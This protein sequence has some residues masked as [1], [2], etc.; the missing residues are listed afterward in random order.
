[1]GTWIHEEKYVLFR[2]RELTQDKPDG[3]FGNIVAG[4]DYILS[5][6]SSYMSSNHSSSENHSNDIK[7]ELLDLLKKLPYLDHYLFKNDFKTVIKILESNN[8]NETDKQKKILIIKS[9]QRKLSNYGYLKLYTDMLEKFLKKETPSYY[10]IDVLLENLLFELVSQGH[11]LLYIQEWLKG[12]QMQATNFKGF[13]SQLLNDLGKLNKKNYDCYLKFK[14]PAYV[15]PNK[16]PNM[17]IYINSPPSDVSASLESFFT[18][19]NY[20]A[21]VKVSALDEFAAIEKSKYLLENALKTQH[22]YQLEKKNNFNEYDPSIQNDVILFLGSS[23][24]YKK[25][26][27]K[28]STKNPLIENVSMLLGIPEKNEMVFSNTYQILSRSLYWIGNSD[29]STYETKILHYWIA[30][31]SIFSSASNGKIID[32]VVKF[33]PCFIS[34]YYMLVYSEKL[35]KGVKDLIKEDAKSL[36][37]Y[38]PITIKEFEE[39]NF[40]EKVTFIIE[41]NDRLK[42]YCNNKDVLKRNLVDFTDLFLKDGLGPRIRKINKDVE[43][44]LKRI[45]RMR[46]QFVHEANVAPLSLEKTFERL[47]FV[48]QVVINNLIHL[49]SS[50][51]AAELNELLICKEES[52]NLYRNET[53]KN[54]KDNIKQ[55]IYPSDLFN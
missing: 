28:R 22:L 31:E 13:L 43:N 50:N 9:F 8:A 55:V 12:I 16:L 44:D 49:L 11:S 53:I 48:I 30:L 4:L 3:F 18:N 40:I 51:P 41:Y 29:N 5:E 33:A 42:F 46:N 20:Y 1:M 10:K 39:K 25:I 32:R 45:Y 37:K 17:D 26:N 34:M 52:Y 2:L 19:R 24:K 21:K 54:P 23:N 36:P 35:T 15:L 47:Q 14:K 27:H 6:Y 38:L 7:N